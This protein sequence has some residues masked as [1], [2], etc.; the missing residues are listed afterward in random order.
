MHFIVGRKLVGRASK[1]AMFG[2]RFGS[3]P[4]PCQWRP[5]YC[6]I[7]G[8]E[9]PLLQVDMNQEIYL[10]FF[11]NFYYLWLFLHQ[12]SDDFVQ[13]FVNMNTSN[14]DILR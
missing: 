14:L 3:A 12:N 9:C 8:K 1:A 13:N 7:V 6:R 5:L 11:S 4:F 10:F 2:S